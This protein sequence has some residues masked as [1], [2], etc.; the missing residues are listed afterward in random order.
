MTAPWAVSREYRAAQEAVQ[1]LPAALLERLNLA[2]GHGL[3]AEQVSARVVPLPD[4][5]AQEVENTLRW[6][7][8]EYVVGAWLLRSD[9]EALT[10]RL[11][12][13][14]PGEQWAGLV[15]AAS[16]RWAQ[17]VGTATEE[18][19]AEPLSASARVPEPDTL[20]TVTAALVEELSLTQRR[21]VSAWRWRVGWAVVLTV[22]GTS[23]VGGLMWLGQRLFGPGPDV[24]IGREW[25]ASSGWS[26]GAVRGRKPESPSG[27]FFFSTE[28]ELRPWW[29]VDLEQPRL[30]EAVSVHNRADCCRDR[31]VPLSILVS[32][33][34]RK[35][36]EVARRTEP[37]QRWLFQLPEPVKARFVRLRV[38]RRSWLHLRDVQVF[39]QE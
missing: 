39:T 8:F 23:L 13:L 1:A 11:E 26:A 24:A 5:V 31:A 21:L 34:G 25:Q 35:W 22:L 18:G 12:E 15:A 37:F 16:K 19:E 32:E 6:A 2:R 9:L 4:G 38:E 30:V 3:T 27:A 29:Q 10:Q 33:D 28:H 36:R 20:R 7:A 17:D 14:I